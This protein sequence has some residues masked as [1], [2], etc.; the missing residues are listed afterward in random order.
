MQ[1]IALVTGAN[2]FIGANLSCKLVDKGYIVYGIF[3][4]NNS[5]N[6]LFNEYVND[7][8]IVHYQGDIRT[9]DFSKISKV[10]YIFHIAGK[11]SV[12]GKLKDFME[13]NYYGTLNLLNYAI[14]QNI[15]NF[16][17]YSSTAVYGFNR[18]N[19]KEKDVKIPFKNPYSLSKL[20]TE[21]LVM[22]KCK[23]NNINYLI[24]RPGNVYGEYDYTSSYEIYKRIKREK[25]SICAGGKYLSCFVYVGNLNDAVIHL[26]KDKS[27]MNTDYNITDGNNETLKTL[28]TLIADTFG[29]KAKFFNFPSFL[30]KFT[31]SCVEGFY[32]FFRIKK[33][34]LITRFSIYQN[35]GD[36]NFSIEKL[37]NTGYEPTTSM[38]DGVRKTV[39]WFNGIDNETKN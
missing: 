21:E 34:P 27:T 35:C 20:A 4:R 23:K 22:D 18:K 3:R 13:V 11:V 25:M 8:K 5:K 2:G 12:Y 19:I 30:A 29:V 10:D 33:A 14:S 16:I 26:T 38:E 37:K 36:Y 15:S 24:V 7:G 31:A 32:K 17:Y 9:F 6:P 39:E 28:F 1:K